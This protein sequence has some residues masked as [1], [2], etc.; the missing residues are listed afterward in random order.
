MTSAR[1][2]PVSLLFEVLKGQK[3]TNKQATAGVSLLLDAHMVSISKFYA[4]L[5]SIYDKLLRELDP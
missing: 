1:K 5:L 3:Q 4:M 2:S